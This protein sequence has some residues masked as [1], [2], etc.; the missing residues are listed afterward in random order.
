MKSRIYTTAESHD[1]GDA[2]LRIGAGRIG[3]YG[4]TLDGIAATVRIARFIL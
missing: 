1:C 4:M 2:G 3:V